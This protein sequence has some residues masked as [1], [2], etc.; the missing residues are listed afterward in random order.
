MK[1]LQHLDEIDKILE[2]VRFL[3][4]RKEKLYDGCRIQQSIKNCMFWTVEE[5]GEVSTCLNRGRLEAAKAECLDLLHTG[6]IL[7]RS[8]DTK[9]K[10]ET[11]DENNS[12]S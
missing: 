12:N 11:P 9:I 2:K 7:Y 5:L 4:K 10:Q 8:I 6:L 3:A 1:N